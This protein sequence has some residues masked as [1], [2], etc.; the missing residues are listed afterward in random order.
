LFKDDY[1]RLR[2]KAKNKF[3]QKQRALRDAIIKE[4]GEKKG[5]N[6]TVKAR[7]QNTRFL[8]R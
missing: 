7:A 4:Y 3:R 6:G 8:V 5:I 2:R 1:D